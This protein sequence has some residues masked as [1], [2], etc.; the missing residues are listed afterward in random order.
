MPQLVV[1][2]STTTARRVAEAGLDVGDWSE[3]EGDS[4]PMLRDTKEYEDFLF[5]LG[6]CVLPTKERKR[7][8]E[9]KLSRYMTVWLEAFAFITYINSYYTWMSIYENRSMSSTAVTS[10]T[11]EVSDISNVAGITGGKAAQ[12][13][14]IHASRGKKYCGWSDKGLQAYNKIVEIL[15]KQR[16]EDGEFEKRLMERFR[17][18]GGKK[19]RGGKQSGQAKRVKNGLQSLRLRLGASQIEGMQGVP[20]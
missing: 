9:E 4:T 14:T 18:E 2:T 3:D 1:E 17:T 6:P 19:R 12:L 10:V 5:H 7:C 15:E 8:A 16:E 13:F 11:E 20:V